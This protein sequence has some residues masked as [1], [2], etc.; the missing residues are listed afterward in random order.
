MFIL[1]SVALGEWQIAAAIAFLPRELF[2]SDLLCLMKP[3]F[4]G[5]LFKHLRRKSIDKL[6]HG[7]KMHLAELIVS[8]ILLFWKLQI[9]CIS[10]IAKYSII[11]HSLI[12][13]SKPPK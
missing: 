1:G 4:Q 5:G 6:T 8:I 12:R 10:E 13:D 11:V 7:S 2:K 9:E 3:K